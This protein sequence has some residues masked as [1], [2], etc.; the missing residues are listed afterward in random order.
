[1]LPIDTNI[2]VEPETDADYRERFRPEEVERIAK[3]LQLDSLWG[4]CKIT[5]TASFDKFTETASLI[6]ASFKSLEDFKQSEEYTHL[7]TEALAAL[8]LKI[9]RTKSSFEKALAQ[10]RQNLENKPQTPNLSE[11][12]S[13]PNSQLSRS[14]KF[15]EEEKKE[16]FENVKRRNPSFFTF[17]DL[18]PELKSKTV[19]DGA[20]AILTIPR[21]ER[22]VLPNGDIIEE[23]GTYIHNNGVKKTLIMESGKVVGQRIFK[24]DG[25]EMKPG[26]VYTASDGMVVIMD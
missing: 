19:N 5:F 21:G 12:S 18:S 20:M 11:S 25:T 23:D 22:A 17:D 6:Y 26:E 1:M 24:P 8:H 9:D 2:T 16:I 13:N 7:E 15:T 14:R 10:Y 3:N 4:W